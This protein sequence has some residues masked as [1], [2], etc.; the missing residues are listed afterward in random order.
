MKM[1]MRKETVVYDLL[2]GQAKIAMRSADAF[3]AM[4][5]DFGNLPHHAKVLDE[6][7]GEGDTLTHELQNRL[8]TM[9]ITPLDKEDLREL[10]QALDDVTDLIEA[11]AARAE[12]YSLTGPREDLLPV[13]ELLQHLTQLTDSAIRELRNGFSKSVSLRE[14]LREIH[15]V[16]N[17]SDKAFRK[18]LKNLFDQPGIEAL[19]VIKWKEM[20]DRIE[21]ASDKCEH[22]A[23]IVGTIID[24]YA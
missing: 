14:T 9:F 4:V 17:Q 1:K 22:I 12:L 13:V 18:A 11:A 10:S 21:Q 8:A 16:E 7:E 6:L 2:E 19:E 3:L 20:F 5:H 15:T 24:K 23:A